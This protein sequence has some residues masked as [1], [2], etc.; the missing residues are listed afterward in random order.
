MRSPGRGTTRSEAGVPS[1][2]TVYA[3]EAQ[4]TE[5]HLIIGTHRGRHEIRWE[6]C[7]EKLAQ[8]MQAERALLGLSPSG[9]SIRW[10]LL[11]EDLAI[12]PLIMPR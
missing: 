4:A 9:C 12:G 1:S 3:R 11:D 2:L 5:T 10:P 7:S 6:L 8:A